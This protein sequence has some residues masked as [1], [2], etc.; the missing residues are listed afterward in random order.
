LPVQ[1][2]FPAAVDEVTAWF[3]AQGTS[4]ATRVPER[5]GGDRCRVW[6]L[7]PGVASLADSCVSVVLNADFPATA[8]RLEVSK[9]LCLRFP[10]V[11]A[12]GHLCHGVQPAP[13]DFDA[14]VEAVGRVL[15]RL[16]EFLVLCQNL[17]WME[18]EFHRERRD[19]WSRHVALGKASRRRHR[20]DLLLDIDVNARPEQELDAVLLGQGFKALATSAAAEPEKVAAHRG[21]TVG[22]LVRGG[23][24]VVRLPDAERWTPSTWPRTFCELDELL[25]GITSVQGRLS[26]WYGSRRWPNKAP[27]MVA[28]LQGTAVFGFQ[29]LPASLPKLTSPTLLPIEVSR[30]DRQWCLSRDHRADA[31][32]T[33]SSKRVVVLGCG[34]LGSQ[35]IQLLARA[36]VGSL[37]V[38]DPQTFETENVSRHLLGLTSAGAGKAATVCARVE[39]DVPGAKLTPAG[40]SAAHW[41]AKLRRD[42]KFDLVV[43][44]TGERSVRLAL[45]R[46]RATLLND[47]PVVMAWME[48]G[49]S[50]AHVVVV[51][52]L[53]VWP[54]CDPAETSVNVAVW[55]DGVEVEVAG[56]GAGFHPYGMADAS[57]AAGL[58]S[59]R[60]LAVLAGNSDLAPGN[61]LP[62]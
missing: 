25:S 18:A 30:V 36:G 8:A 13:E 42:E 60:A 11:E 1:S 3:A 58:A 28:L 53:D 35:V 32:M 21:W 37:E 46:V 20:V 31:L 41:L 24:L 22:T 19:Y 40:V 14:P 2:L 9:K 59:E 7:E 16:D 48:P 51:N 29:L 38:V 5:E 44:C 10:H 62:C 43:D 50:A 12:D 55:P 52:G 17:G 33:L 34:S 4:V 39:R 45:S 54:S 26:N 23:C 6:R 47:A 57:R 15:D 49:C 27:V 61:R 56:C